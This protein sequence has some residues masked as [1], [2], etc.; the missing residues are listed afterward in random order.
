MQD[1]VVIA[2]QN[3]PDD[4]RRRFFGRQSAL[5]QNRHYTPLKL[6]RFVPTETVIFVARTSFGRIPVF[7]IH[8]ARAAYDQF[9]IGLQEARRLSPFS[10]MRRTRTHYYVLKPYLWLLDNFQLEG[11]EG[12]DAIPSPFYMPFS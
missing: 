7:D 3:Q 8:D 4:R 2:W 5:M 11:V 12:N 10:G 1:W 9:T 6:N